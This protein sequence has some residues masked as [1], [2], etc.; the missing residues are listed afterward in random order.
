[1]NIDLTIDCEDPW[2][3]LLEKGIK[4]VEGRKGKEK[5]ISLKSGDTIRFQCTNSERSFIATVQRVDRFNNLVDY[6][7]E[8]TLEKA[9]PGISTLEEGIRIY[10]AWSA[11]E[12]IQKLGFVAIW[13]TV[14]GPK[15]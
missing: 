1:M 3:S 6:L 9:L 5:Y 12:E 2:F 14:K 7:N 8:V 4:P 15:M 13:I 10:S 11:P